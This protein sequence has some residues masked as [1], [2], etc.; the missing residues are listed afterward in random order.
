MALVD[1]I[2][3]DIEH[4]LKRVTN[5]ELRI[6]NSSLVIRSAT[7][8]FSKKKFFFERM[9]SSQRFSKAARL[10]KSTEFQKVFAARRVAA[11][12]V[13]VVFGLENGSEYSRLGL[14]VSRKVGK[15]VVRN[16]WKRLIR[17]AFRKNRTDFS[18]PLDLVVVPQ[19]GAKLPT[20]RQIEESLCRL[21]GRLIAKGRK[22]NLPGKGEN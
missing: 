19:K 5:D 14:S 1:H 22:S 15:A 20:D 3:P 11:D 16:R 13:L 4:F 2:H 9:Q 6:T 7:P 10:R 8:Q 21:V 12:D 17:E 18:Q